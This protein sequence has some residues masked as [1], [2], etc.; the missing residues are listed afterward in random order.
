MY[1]SSSS[2]G[3]AGRVA[4]VTVAGIPIN[5]ATTRAIGNFCHLAFLYR[6][7]MDLVATNNQ[8]NW[9]I[10]PVSALSLSFSSLLFYYGSPYH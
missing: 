1:C 5:R 8:K 9:H 2:D 6:S 3:I 10:N 7:M 4:T